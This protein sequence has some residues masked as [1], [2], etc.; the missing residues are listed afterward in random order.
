[1]NIITKLGEIKEEKPPQPLILAK[2]KIQLSCRQ[3]NT[4]ITLKG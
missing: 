3:T 4:W 2:Y 1:M